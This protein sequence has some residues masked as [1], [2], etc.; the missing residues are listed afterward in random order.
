MSYPLMQMPTWAEFVERAKELGATYQTHNDMH[1]SRPVETL[2]V[3]DKWIVRPVGIRDSKRLEP[4]TVRSMAA[5]LGLPAK[6]FG[7]HLDPN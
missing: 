5:R 1:S 6:D 2:W 4:N 3:G 7:L